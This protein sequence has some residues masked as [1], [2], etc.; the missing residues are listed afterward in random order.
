MKTRKTRKV[1]E[2]AFL[3]NSS[4]VHKKSRKITFWK[5]TFRNIKVS[6]FFLGT[7]FCC[8]LKTNLGLSGKAL[9]GLL[10]W[11]QTFYGSY[12]SAVV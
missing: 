8:F 12:R 11:V 6:S 5:T 4:A 1:R 3:E 9:L 10:K 2:N 7:F